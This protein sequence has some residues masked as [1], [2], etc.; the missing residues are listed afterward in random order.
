[1]KEW[2]TMLRPMHLVVTL[3]ASD[4]LR[5]ADSHSFDFPTAES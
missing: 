3:E 1:M 5:L 4:Q 2:D